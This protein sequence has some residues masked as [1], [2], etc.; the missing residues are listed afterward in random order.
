[1]RSFLTYVKVRQSNEGEKMPPK[2]I[3]PPVFAA[4]FLLGLILFQA[5]VFDTG[6][7]SA[8]DNQNKTASDIK[9]AETFSVTIR[10]LP[11]YISIAGKIRSRTMMR[12]SSQL[13]AKVKEV[14]VRSGDKVEAGQLL[15]TL[16]NRTCLARLDHARQN[17]SAAKT[18]T[19]Q[20][21]QAHASAR[22]AYD[23]AQTRYA[24]MKKM[25]ADGAISKQ[26]MDQDKAAFLQAQAMLNQTK[27][28]QKEAA[29]LV[30][31]AQETLREAQIKIGYTQIRAQ[32]AGEIITRTV[33]PGELASVGRQLFELRTGNG[34][35]LEAIVP[36]RYI[37]RI[38]EGQSVTVRIDSAGRDLAAKIVEI[39][40]VADPLSR[41]FMIKAALPGGEGL[42]PGMFGRLSFKIGSR[43]QLVIPPEYLFKVGQLEMVWV[44]TE[45]S[46]QRILV[47]TGKRQ[48]EGIVI[49]SGL[50]ESDTIGI[51]GQQP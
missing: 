8:T 16:D 14:F 34:L 7:I 12:V 19:A 36:E 13:A 26:D 49:L 46:W 39:A 32:E 22:A 18:R 17:L 37:G 20:A 4:C 5:G 24:R 6:K 33:E 30:Q 47:T 1:M 31:Q 51:P 35:Q 2:K 28:A 41:I 25:L 15:V 45:D 42:F 9:M 29:L 23:M 3:L 21:E 11:E 40:P 50:T 43:R 38:Q 10:E 44:R 48:P 27:E